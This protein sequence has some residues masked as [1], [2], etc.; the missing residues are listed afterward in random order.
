MQAPTGPGSRRVL[1]AWWAAAVAAG[2]F[3]VLVATMSRLFYVYDEAI[4]LVGAMRVA[5]GEIPHRDFYST[6][7]PAPYYL[8]AALF[9]VFGENLLIERLWDATIKATTVGLVF[10]LLARNARAQ[11]ALV[12]ALT[13]LLWQITVGAYAYV[14][15]SVVLLGIASTGLLLPSRSGQIGRA[16][17]Y[18]AGALVGCIALFRYETAFLLALAHG[19]TAACLVLC[20]SGGDA[21]ARWRIIRG[22]GLRYTLGCAV[23]FGP[24]AAYFLGNGALQGFLFDMFG[25]NARHYPEMRRLPWPRPR[26]ILADIH[27]A[28]VYLPAATLCAAGAFLVTIRKNVDPAAWRTRDF[29]ALFC[30]LTAV[31]FVK[32]VVRVSTVHMHMAIIGA[33]LLVAVMADRLLNRR[34]AIGRISCTMS[35][36]TLTSLSLASFRDHPGAVFA[37]RSA[38]DLATMP[39]Q[40]RP[41]FV[42]PAF[43][44][45]A[46]F[47][48][49]HTRPTERIFVGRFH[50]DQFVFNAI[51]IYFAAGRLPGTHWHQFD[52][53][54]QT[55]LEIQRKIIVDLATYRVRYVVLTNEADTWREPNASARS[56]GVHVLDDYIRVNFRLVRRWPEVEVW[57]RVN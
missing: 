8:L 14:I 35:L 25:F 32:G 6:Y 51:S 1:I 52:P 2:A 33:T 40:V 54:L 4:P 37:A 57:R 20:R 7:G 44:E 9:K 11:V 34:D 48:A 31:F 13:V 5:A 10:Y 21:G 36:V 27:L 24:V 22:A 30:A 28:A 29:L 18:A 17:C 19:V 45:A 46:H 39:P 55:S 53:G 26:E 50:H 23:V 41:A 12:A 47:V 56:S 42:A 43:A 3:L 49:T 38:V 16:R 15:H